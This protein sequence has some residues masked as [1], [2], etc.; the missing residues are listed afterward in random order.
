MAV[1]VANFRFQVDE[2]EMLNY[3]QNRIKI[4][5]IEYSYLQGQE[6][7]SLIPSNNLA[8]LAAKVL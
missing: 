8:K 4:G 2:H 1:L 6:I 7:P 5:L 3:R